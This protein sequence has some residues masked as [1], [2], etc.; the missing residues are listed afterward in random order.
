MAA[1]G[2]K[3]PWSKRALWAALA[4]VALIGIAWAALTVAFPPARVRALVQRQLTAA[5]AREVRF[6]GAR[7]GLLPPVRLTV[8]G[9]E[10]A[11]PGGF[12]NGRAFRAR[13][14]HLDLDILALLFGRVTVRRLVLD[15]PELH[16]VMRGDGT[17]NLDGIA[18]AQ[19]PGRAPARPMDL[20]VRDL[21]VQ[22]GRLVVDGL[23]TARRTACGIES[24]FAFSSKAGGARLTTSGKT[25]I[26][27]LARGP[28][29]ARRLADLDPSLA[30]LIWNIEHCGA[31]EAGRKRLA[32]ERLALRLGRTELTLRGVVDEP[33][34][35]ARFALTT[36][37]E[38]V[39]LSE[40]MIFLAAT[41]AKALNGIEASGRV[42][43]DLAIRGQLGLDRPPVIA[44]RLHVEDGAFRY[45]GAPA[46]VEALRFS[47]RFAPDSLSI[48]DL[49]A[50]VTGSRGA[51]PT[52]VRA[53]LA[54]T[55]FA[56]PLVAFTLRG[57]V[58]LAAIAPLVAPRDTRLGG[59][60]VL[61]LQGRG[62][63]KDPGA[64]ALQGRARLI[65]VEIESPDLP[66][67][68][69]KVEGTVDF[70]QERA[71]LRGLSA[72]A[73]KSSFALDGTVS[74]PLA[75][76]AKPGST[77]PAGVD[78]QLKSPY[79]DL[80]ELLPTAPGA[81][82]VPNAV[83]GGRV[84]IGRLKSQKL[85]VAN[86]NARVDLD[87]GVV[88]VS[89]FQLDGYGG[90]ISGSA[91]FDLRDPA[92][93]V[94]ALKARADSIQADALLSIWTPARNFLRGSLNTSMDLSVAGATPDQ[95]KRSITAVGLALLANGQ[96]GPGPALEAIAKLTQV[97]RLADLKFKDMRLPFRI[98]RGRVVTDP[99]ELRGPYG[100][101]KMAGAIGFDGALDY[102]LSVTLPPQIVA[103]LN[104]RSALAAGALADERGNLL[105]DL[106]VSGTTKAPR[107]AWDSRAMRD[108]LAGKASQALEAQR[109][110]I[111]RELLEEVSRRRQAAADSARAAAERYRRAAADSLRR[112]AGDVLKGFFG[113][114][115]DTSRP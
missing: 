22:R 16:L 57:D 4:L 73:G 72:R 13:S 67:K 95:I 27:D 6:A 34:P 63:A 108:R 20:D 88:R 60:A 32:L 109:Q 91:S 92:T 85:D 106:R 44:G 31:F 55:R 50:R 45:A 49:Q 104:A 62:R 40:V 87:P 66:R 100:E 89:N 99:V 70:S 74:R 17:T 75:L 38:A 71:G 97:P 61:D 86:V 110:K 1:P 2:K 29:S 9:P 68:V 84:R 54:V 24:R 107:V 77:A 46:G 105:V 47:A 81:P 52:P 103:D 59:R 115:P 39:S 53:Q 14:L 48:G 25:R 114:E 94:V 111:E 28:L 3:G 19:V 83:G 101:W 36:R 41:E 42:D 35:R 93:P 69:E 64:M 65:A 30:R 37:G 58:N 12:A 98:E 76:L 96:L 79:L 5:L 43:F 80:A 8:V 11:E 113:G 90:A 78:F 10:L 23:K 33:G 26:S 18:R 7:I 102:A 112:R 82:L 21:V 56:D 51:G 15:R